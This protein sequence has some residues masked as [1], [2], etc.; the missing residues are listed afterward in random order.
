MVTYIAK[1]HN[2][3]QLILDLRR[4]NAQAINLV[5]LKCL[6]RM[7]VFAMLSTAPQ[8][9]VEEGSSSVGLGGRTDLS[10]IKCRMLNEWQ[11]CF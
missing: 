8:V 9:S 1:E 5:H 11:K 4:K 10:L 7:L 2:L 3:F 6:V